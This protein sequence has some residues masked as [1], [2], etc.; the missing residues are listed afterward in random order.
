MEALATEALKLEGLSRNFGALEVLKNV[1]LDV[2]AGEYVAII[3]PNGSGKT[4][5]F[6]VIGG[7][8][9]ATAGRIYMFGQEITN[10]PPYRRTHLGLARS[11]Q[12]T[13]LFYDLTILDN[14]IIAIH[15]KRHSRYQ[16][17]RST[18]THGEVVDKAKEMLESVD[19]WEKRSELAKTLSYGEQRKVEI[20]LR[21]ALEPRL[22]LLDEPSAGLSIAERPEFIN[23]T[24]S[25]AA[26]TTVIF[27]EHDMDVVFQLADRVLVLYYG[28]F[29]A[30]G[31][32]N[33]IRDN[34][35]VREIYLGENRSTDNA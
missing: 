10:L 28:Q 2:E 26:G 32:P 35:R 4:T 18:S 25:L 20:I 17:L 19:L 14:I 9:Q 24:K 13:S 3:G 1:Y 22:L 16:L 23:M 5:L 29:I 30:D 7:Q 21:L 31:T 15:G 34:A 6:N 8:L 11:F 27:A 33:E 12:I